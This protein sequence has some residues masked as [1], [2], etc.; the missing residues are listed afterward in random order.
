MIPILYVVFSVYC[1]TDADKAL[2]EK[3]RVELQKLR[4]FAGHARYGTCW[5]LA[6]GKV[7][8][9]CRDFNEDTQSMLA[10]GFTH[11]HLRRSE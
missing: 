3:G 5:S 9:N 4:E 1:V 6:L 8:A 10:L 7:H 11:C 2:A